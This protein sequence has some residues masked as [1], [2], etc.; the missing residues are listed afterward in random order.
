MQIILQ[1]PIKRFGVPVLLA[2]LHL[3]VKP[4]AV[5]FLGLQCCC[6]TFLGIAELHGIGHGDLAGFGR[7]I[8]VGAHE[9]EDPVLLLQ[10]LNDVGDGL[11][12]VF[13]GSIF[14]AIRQH[15]AEHGVVRLPLMYHPQ[16]SYY[17]P[18]GGHNVASWHWAGSWHP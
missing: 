14:C 13:L 4:L 18:D 16:L 5:V 9:D 3:F 12:G 15:T 8:L 11:P 17:I 7:N 10:L 1:V 6:Y 2:R